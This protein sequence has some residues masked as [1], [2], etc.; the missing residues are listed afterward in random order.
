[1][2]KGKKKE[3]GEKNDGEVGG[4]VVRRAVESSSMGFC[5][6]FSVKRV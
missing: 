1:M 6:R 5:F 2:R 3:K 4:L